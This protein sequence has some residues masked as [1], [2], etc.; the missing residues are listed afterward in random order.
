[1]LVGTERKYYML[2]GKGGVGKTS[3][4]ASLAVQLSRAGHP[5]LVVSTDPAHSLSDALDQD[6]SGGAPVLL[7]GTDLPLWGM[8]ID[9]EAAKQELRALGSK[10]DGKQVTDFLNSVGLGGFGEQLRDLQLGELLDSPPPGVDEAV[11]I[12]KVVEFLTQPEYAKFTRIVFDTAP[13]GHTL[14]LLTL[15]DF[16]DTTVGKVVRLRQKILDAANAVKGV[17]GVKSEKDPAVEKLEAL[18]VRWVVLRWLNSV[19]EDVSHKR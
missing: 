1:M 5:T 6:V 19:C 4:A 9:V 2:G 3:S 18:K 15:P 14:R 16:L 7:A 8:E 17:F 11:A 12:S 13:T 10:D